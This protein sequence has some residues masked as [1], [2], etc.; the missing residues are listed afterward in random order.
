MKQ[1][2]KSGVLEAA[3]RCAHYSPH[4]DDVVAP[5]DYVRFLLRSGRADEAGWRQCWRGPCTHIIVQEA[6]ANEIRVY[7]LQEQFVKAESTLDH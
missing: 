5:A 7:A 1:E 4:H 6:S 2:G 3:A